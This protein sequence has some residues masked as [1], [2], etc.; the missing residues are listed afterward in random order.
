MLNERDNETVDLL[1]AL[2]KN[3]GEEY[4]VPW[5]RIESRRSGGII[6]LRTREQSPAHRGDL[7]SV[8]YSSGVLR[9]LNLSLRA[10]CYLAI[11]RA[12]GG[13]CILLDLFDGPTRYRGEA[14]T[15]GE[16]EII[17]AAL[18]QVAGGRIG[19]RQLAQDRG[20]RANAP[21]GNG[22]DG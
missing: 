6:H 19:P 18:A 9:L 8:D 17:A 13:C 7:P 10:G 11:W 20:F 2:L 15:G 12:S 4:V 16:L 5:S 3:E 14:T 1:S 22:V 21:L